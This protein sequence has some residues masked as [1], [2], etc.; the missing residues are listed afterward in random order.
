M[1][2]Q[3]ALITLGKITSVYGVKGWLKIFSYTDP[4][5]QILDY[6]EWTLTRDGE[7]K[8]VRADK[9]KSHGKGMIAHLEGV[10]DRATA[11]TFAGFEIRVERAQLPELAE[12]E[13]YWWQ[14]EGCSVINTEGRDLGRVSHLIS[15]GGANDVMIVHSTDPQDSQHER[16]IPYVPG[17]SVESVDLDAER[18]TVDWDPDF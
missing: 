12:G 14:L 6:P 13:Y 17:V 4:M 8:T 2:E 11:E 9:G 5:D 18:I 1:S 15:A 3:S 10:N 16:L 7:V